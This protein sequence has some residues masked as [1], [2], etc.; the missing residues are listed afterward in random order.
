MKKPRLPKKPKKV[1][2]PKEY[3][4]QLTHETWFSTNSSTVLTLEE[5]CASITQ[6]YAKKLKLD[7]SK[8]KPADIAIRDV[9]CTIGKFKLLRD[10]NFAKKQKSYLKRL[11]LAKGSLDSY[12]EQLKKYNI[13]LDIYNAWLVKQ[14]EDKLKDKLKSI[15]KKLD[16]VKREKKAL[17]DTCRDF[18][19]KTTN[20]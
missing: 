17:L 11:E 6:K 12:E 5:L 14:R 9:C 18:D 2:K 10:P 19:E 16:E 13:D 1:Y 15:E 4:N 20:S 8:V 3:S 7:A